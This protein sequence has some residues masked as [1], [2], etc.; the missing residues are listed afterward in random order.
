MHWQGEG[1][2]DDVDV[3]GGIDL[4]RGVEEG[5]RAGGGRRQQEQSRPHVGFVRVRRQ[6]AAAPQR[7]SFQPAA[8]RHLSVRSW[9]AAGK[10]GD[11]SRFDHRFAIQRERLIQ[12]IEKLIHAAR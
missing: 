9:R 10:A 2:V 12:F 4:G 1:W 11:E 8:P 3:G 6:T 5:G 7:K